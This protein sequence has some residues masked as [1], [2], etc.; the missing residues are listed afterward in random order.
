MTPLCP[1]TKLPLCAE[2]M[3][4]DASGVVMVVEGGSVMIVESVA[5]ALTEPPP[6]TLTEFTCGETAFDATLTVAVMGG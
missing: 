4:R 1:C 5:E 6:E 3:P 2:A